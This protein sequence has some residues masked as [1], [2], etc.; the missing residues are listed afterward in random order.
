MCAPKGS[1]QRQFSGGKSQ[2]S[3][4]ENLKPLGGGLVTKRQ[5][6]SE[7]PPEQSERCVHFYD[8]VAVFNTFLRFSWASSKE[9][10]PGL[11]R[12]CLF[13]DLFW[14]RIRQRQVL[15]RW[16][17]LRG[18]G[19]VGGLH[20][21]SGIMETLFCWFTGSSQCRFFMELFRDKLLLL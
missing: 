18:W 4:T 16:N 6:F 10:A 2:V 17:L 5:M 20:K 11:R 8:Y 13:F 19:G 21:T 7:R 3:A 1:I 15:F 14:S 12:T 9:A